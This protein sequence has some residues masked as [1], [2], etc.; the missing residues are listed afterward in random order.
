[1]IGKKAFITGIT[2]QD[3]S[4]LAEL[5]LKLDYEVVGVI[6]DKTQLNNIKHI[7]KKIE[8]Y[9]L[10]LTDFSRLKAVILK[11]IPDQIYNLGGVTA[12][13]TF[14][15]DPSYSIKVTEGAARVIFETANHLHK[16]GH[17]IKI[18]QASTGLVFEPFH[19]KSLYARTKFNVDSYAKDLRDQEKLFL[20]CGFLYN[21]E[22]P[23]RSL[24]FV[25]RRI[26]VAAACIYN[27]VTQIPKDGA[28]NPILT[29]D[30]MLKLGNLNA[31]RDWGDARDFVRA[32]LL[33]L[34][35]TKAE[36]FVL[37]TGQTHSVKDVLDIAFGHLGLDWHKHII[38]D[39]E[40]FRPEDSNKLCGDATKARLKL[41]WIPK[42]K[43][44]NTIKDMVEN[45][46]GIFSS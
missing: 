42:I 18:F 7:Y 38:K 19:P 5:L 10:D 32:F 9:E 43:F 29:N 6:R 25:T 11:S 12:L 44:E 39:K 2:G 4:Y 23:R 46:V 24:D 40:S 34:E 20:S 3:G 45:D 37:A 27:S 22:S 26:T 31:K 30:F 17:N 16:L 36:D 35:Q 21:H 41:G 8:L 13:S 14:D 33:M 1:M 15:K 28:G